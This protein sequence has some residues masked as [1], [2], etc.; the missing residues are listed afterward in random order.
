M[1]Y[2]HVQRLWARFFALLIDCVIFALVAAVI[3]FPF[4]S[5]KSSRFIGGLGVANWHSC[6]DGT[7]IY[8]Q[9]GK[10]ISMQ[11]WQ[12]IVICDHVRDFLFSYRTGTFVNQSQNGSS[13][14]TQQVTFPIDEK[15]WITNKTDLS[16]FYWLVFVA[17][18]IALE[19]LAGFTPG[20]KF[21]GLKVINEFGAPP[22]L[23]RATIRNALKYLILV[24]IPLFLLFN[25]SAMDLAGQTLTP[26]NTVVF[27]EKFFEEF[28]PTFSIMIAVGI[29]NFIFV[30]SIL[31]PWSNKGRAL[32]DRL[33]G[34]K[35]VE[36]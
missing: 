14:Y 2:Q 17:A 34:T 31:F 5:G 28:L 18:T 13:T 9:E 6:E 22:G 21:L 10:P 12:K 3:S 25:P 11:G 26:Q 7:A 23:G 1:N 33:A 15:S 36:L 20:K 29:A 16:D 30:W 19:G 35:V 32:Y 27:P 8:S 24:P 4:A